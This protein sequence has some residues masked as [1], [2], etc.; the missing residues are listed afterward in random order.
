LVT[1]FQGNYKYGQKLFK[2]SDRE[3]PYSA[4]LCST[5]MYVFRRACAERERLTASIRK[6]FTS[7]QILDISWANQDGT[8]GKNET[9]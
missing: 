7:K 3:V 4:S 9:W 1:L 6:H 2:T 5:D 8:K